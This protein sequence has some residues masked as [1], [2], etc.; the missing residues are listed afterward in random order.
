[1][2]IAGLQ[3]QT[4]LVCYVV[5]GY[6]IVSFALCMLYRLAGSMMHV[7]VSWQSAT[8]ASYAYER[9]VFYQVNLKLARARFYVNIFL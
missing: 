9:V 8:I 4:T 2:H 7:S 6:N 1:M 5:C 3:L